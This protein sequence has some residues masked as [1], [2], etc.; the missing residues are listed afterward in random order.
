MSTTVGRLRFWL[1]E[2]RTSGQRAA[3]FVARV[4]GTRPLKSDIM[5]GMQIIRAVIVVCALSAVALAT[6]ACPEKGPAEKAGEKIDNAV[7]KTKD[8]A[9]DATK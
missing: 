9:K 2:R 1:R 4:G 3:D 8:A 5:S 7:D 6:S